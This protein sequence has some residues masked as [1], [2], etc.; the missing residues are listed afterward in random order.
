MTLLQNYERQYEDVQNMITKYEEDI[1]NGEVFTPV[2]T[3]I[4]K[5]LLQGRKRLG[6]QI[7]R[8]KKEMKWWFTK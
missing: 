2:K 7:K 3:K 4:Y 8:L 1:R 5:G 6:R